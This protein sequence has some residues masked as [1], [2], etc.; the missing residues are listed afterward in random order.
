MTLYSVTY[1]M[2]VDFLHFVA[3]PLCTIADQPVPVIYLAVRH[4]NGLERYSRPDRSFGPYITQVPGYTS[5]P[6][7]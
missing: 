5:L 4:M 7:H 6:C 3:F 2:T 1:I